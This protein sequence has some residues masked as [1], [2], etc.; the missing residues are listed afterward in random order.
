MY[1]TSEVREKRRERRKRL[2]R[3]VVKGLSRLFCFQAKTLEILRLE[4][5]SVDDGIDDVMQEVVDQRTEQRTHNIAQRMSLQSACKVVES[6]HGVLENMACE[7][8]SENAAAQESMRSEV[9]KLQVEMAAIRVEMKVLQ[10]EMRRTSALC[11][12]DLKR[13]LHEVTDARKQAAPYW[14]PYVPKAVEASSI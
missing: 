13:V 1:R 2:R 8:Q 6:T 3:R 10:E 12:E 7:V 9:Q 14:I 4:V 11:H 5:G